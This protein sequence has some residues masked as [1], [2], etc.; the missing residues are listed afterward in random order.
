MLVDARS[1]RSSSR[2]Q[3]ALHEPKCAPGEAA[4]PRPEHQPPDEK[5]YRPREL[6]DIVYLG[7]TGSGWRG[8]GWDC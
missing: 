3:P 2:N 6:G 5:S 1:G 8:M 4:A 7:D